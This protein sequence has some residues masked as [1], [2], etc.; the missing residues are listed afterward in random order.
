MVAHRTRPEYPLYLGMTHLQ[1][2]GP[3]DAQRALGYFKEALAIRSNYAP[4]HYQSGIALQ[5]MR[6]GSNAISHFS[7]AVLADPGYP[8][9][10]QALGRALTA[11]GRKL[12]SHRYLGR[13]YDLKDRPEAA[14]READEMAEAAPDRVAPALFAGQVYLRTQQAEKAMAVTEAALKRHP[15]DP[16]LLERLAVLKL[17]RGDRPAARR[18]LHQWLKLE[19]KASRPCWLLGR[20]EMAELKYAEA[21]AWLE[22]AIARQPN[23]PYYLGFLGAAL[24]RQGTPE[25]RPRAVEVLAKT[26]ALTPDDAEYRDLYG[27][28]LRRVGRDEEALRQFL[29]ALDLS[30]SRVALYTPVSQLAWRLRRPG[31]AAYF[32]PLVRAVQSR[33]TEENALWPHVWEN[34]EDAEGRLRLA[35]FF[36]RTAQLTRA[37]DHLEQVLEQRPGWQPAQTL[38]TT[39][40]RALEVTD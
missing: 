20:C 24:V 40:Q 23:N 39:V 35:R 6:Q 26:V 18:L 1:Q 30:P 32:P 4:A 28:A 33:V 3:G 2:D 13:Y 10:N 5:R 17:N 9:P 7:F 21:I 16:Q 15:N 22:K 31:P 8:E 38:M 11:V 36:C 14:V 12:E 34:P 29:R 37:R 19:P 27:Q 25:S